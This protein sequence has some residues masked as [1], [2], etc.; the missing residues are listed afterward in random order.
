MHDIQTSTLSVE[1]IALSVNSL[2]LE[3]LREYVALS[4]HIHKGHYTTKAEGVV[5]L[6]MKKNKI[7]A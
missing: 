6:T 1:V 4:R 3:E 2:P 5:W 7:D